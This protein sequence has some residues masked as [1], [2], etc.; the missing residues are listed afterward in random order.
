MAAL[1]RYLHAKGVHFGICECGG[2]LPLQSGRRGVRD[3]A[4]GWCA[5]SDEGTRTCGG[6]PGSEGHE[7][8]D[9]R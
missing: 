4:L 3:G 8:L 5:D 6:F 1:G 9:A 2:R 7:T